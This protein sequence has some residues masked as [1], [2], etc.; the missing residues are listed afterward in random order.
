[1]FFTAANQGPVKKTK[2]STA[3]YNP[4]SKHKGKGKSKTTL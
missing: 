3:I 1:M 4:Q 2:K